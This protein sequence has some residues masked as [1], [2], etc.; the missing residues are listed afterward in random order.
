MVGRDFCIVRNRVTQ[1]N[2]SFLIFFIRENLHFYGLTNLLVE[3]DS[4]I[5]VVRFK[6][7]GHNYIIGERF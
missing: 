2:V 3:Y 1:V 4:L 6:N 7:G 5:T